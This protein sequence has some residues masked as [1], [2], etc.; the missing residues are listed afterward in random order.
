MNHEEHSDGAERSEQHPHVPDRTSESS[1][2]P[3]TP[4][5]PDPQQPGLQQSEHSDSTPTQQ[6]L[7]G[8]S[9]LPGAHPPVAVWEHY[10]PTPHPAIIQ[11]YNDIC[12][13]SGDRIMDDAHEDMLLDRKIT[14]ESFD[15]AVHES[16]V[17]LYT[18]VA[19]IAC[20][21]ALIPV[22]LI[23]LDPPESLVG[24]GAL[25]LVAATPLVS[26]LLNSDPKNSRAQPEPQEEG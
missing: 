15:Y 13:G 24:V 16:K 1:S 5:Q 3:G 12:P 4:P 6:S 22:L 19:L 10:G 2:R 18:A 23:I 21:V 14:K 9:N 17:R 8:L 25:G 20:A 11:Y 7:P 26:T